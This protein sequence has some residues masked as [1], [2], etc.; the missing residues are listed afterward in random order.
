[1]ILNLNKFSN[2]KT[3]SINLL[4]TQNF[5]QKN[6]ITVNEVT[7]AHY[8]VEGVQMYSPSEIKALKNTQ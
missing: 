3:Q 8:T 4:S 1:M 6:K 5:L 2:D 7:Q